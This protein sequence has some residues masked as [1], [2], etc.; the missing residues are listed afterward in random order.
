M[1]P[2]DRKKRKVECSANRG[3][4]RNTKRASEI[5]KYNCGDGV[6]S[7]KLRSHLTSNQ[8]KLDSPQNLNHSISYPYFHFSSLD[9]VNSTLEVKRWT[10]PLEEECKKWKL[11]M[12]S[13]EW[14]AESIRNYTQE[15]KSNRSVSHP[16]RGRLKRNDT[17]SKGN[18]TRKTH[19]GEKSQEVYM[20][21]QI[22]CCQSYIS[23]F[24]TKW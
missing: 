7:L 12:I 22:R 21:Y 1:G 6:Q 17:T 4:L 5:I 15:P 23:I 18:E 9:D 3:K 11:I 10:Q 24:E 20:F 13:I 8:S 19:S 14:I 2:Q 16:G